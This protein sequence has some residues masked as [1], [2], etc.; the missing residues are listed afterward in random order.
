MLI[1]CSTLQEIFGPVVSV[2]VYEDKD[3]KDILK[4]LD[5]ST[6]YGLT[7]AVYAED[8]YV[9]RMQ[10]KGDSC[11]GGLISMGGGGGG[12]IF[13]HRNVSLHHWLEAKLKKKYISK[14][15][16]QQLEL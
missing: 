9:C 10:G 2:Y 1:N 13:T 16:N 8:R 11:V 4:L 6:A 3:Y 5:S 15:E 12:F 7:G 14:Q